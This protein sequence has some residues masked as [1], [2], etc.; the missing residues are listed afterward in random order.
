MAP[1]TIPLVAQRF[2]R[3]AWAGLIVIATLACYGRTIDGRFL[4]Y[5]DVDN[6]LENPY[7]NP[8]TWR[9][10]AEFWREPYRGLYMPVTFTWWGVESRLAWDTSVA[11]RHE[12]VPGR[13]PVDPRVFQSGSLLLHVVNALLV[14]VLLI[15]LVP[16]TGAAAAGALLFSLHPLQVESVGWIGANTGLLSTCAALVALGCLLR[17]FDTRAELP[18]LPGSRQDERAAKPK[19]KFR[20][21]CQQVCWPGCRFRPRS[22]TGA[23]EVG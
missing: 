16:S 4:G 22:P 17:Y 8:P 9:H 23:P 12:Q 13:I 1:E 6:V 21:F 3:L 10:L 2:R 14:Y 11:A 18:E 20:R 15:R 19:F 7:L 5:D